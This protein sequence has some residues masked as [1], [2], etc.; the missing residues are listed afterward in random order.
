ME[1][2]KIYGVM[3]IY[4]KCLNESTAFQCLTEQNVE[5]VICDNSTSDYGNAEIAEKSNALYISMEGNKGLSCAYNRAIER[6]FSLYQPQKD[7]YI[8]FFDDDTMVPGE[9]FR[10]LM[11]ENSKILLPIVYDSIGIMSPVSM[12]KGLVRRF[13]S[14]QEAFLSEG[15]YIS[16]INS[17]MAVKSGI[18]ENY[19]YNEKMF[20]DYIDHK[21]IMDM[22]KR[23]IF[24]KILEVEIHQ[25]FS[26]VEDL[27]DAA[28]RRFRMQ[29]KDL[30]VFYQDNLFLYF[31]VVLKKHLKLAIKYKDIR[32]LVC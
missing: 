17:A 11:K 3:V 32:M 9:Y 15:R 21:F 27:K 28:V 19:R 5:L 30:K 22:R 1:H 13:R 6:I 25:N 12:K 8:C 26:A 16:G 10:F 2:I 20:L 31:F 18:F 29:K 24:P 4:N 23:E 14:K 7:D